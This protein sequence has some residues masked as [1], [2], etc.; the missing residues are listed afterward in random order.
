MDKESIYELQKI[1]CNC[2][3]CKFMI[4]DF[5]TFKSFDTLYQGQEKASHRIHYG[6]C[7]KLNKKVSFVPNVCQ[8][9]TQDCFKHRKD[10]DI[11]IT[12][13]PDEDLDDNGN[14]IGNDPYFLNNSLIKK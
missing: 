10:T 1:D 4:R 2:N 3:D 14:Y 12:L 13:P 7:S 5:E 8:L 6:D 9:E 11:I